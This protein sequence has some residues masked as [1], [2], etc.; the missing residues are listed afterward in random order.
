[1]DESPDSGVVAER[2]FCSE[3]GSRLFIH[4][5]KY[6]NAVIVSFGTL[7]LSEEELK[8][9]KPESEFYC[10]RKGDCLVDAGSEIGKK[11]YGYGIG[12]GCC[13]ASVVGVLK[14]LLF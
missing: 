14:M 9:W 8:K 6:P 13:L 7:D 10:K 3:Y 5:P 1:V 4:N 12:I 2:I 11:I